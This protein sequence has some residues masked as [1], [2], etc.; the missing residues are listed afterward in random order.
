MKRIVSW[1]Y[2]HIVLLSPKIEV[3]MRKLYWGNQKLFK[4]FNPFNHKVDII[5]EDVKL[6]F[7]DVIN[8]LKDNGVGPGTLLIV[9]SSYDVIKCFGLSPKE[10][11]DRLLN[12]IGETGTLAMPA[13]RVYTEFGTGLDKMKMDPSGIIC[14]Y[15]K[16]RTPIGTGMLPFTMVR[17]KR[18]VISP[19]PINTM[20]AIGP[21]AEAMMEK[22]MNGECPSPSGPN[23]SWKFCLDHNAKVIGLGVDLEHH[24]SILHTA[25]EAFGDWPWSDEEWY[26]RRHFN[27]V[28]DDKSII[29]RDVYERRPVWGMLHIAEKNLTNYLNKCGVYHRQKIGGLI[30]V[31][32]EDAQEALMCL[33]KKNK[34]G[35]PYFK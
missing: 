1:L 33:R 26:W 2:N 30:P 18:A 29:Q 17:D 9:H 24:N 7:N 21:L 5:N 12:L 27:L 34:N 4:R 28:Q 13:I 22:N 15:D 16:K 6:D 8:F 19:H 35:Y 10:I 3:F 14:T 20:V 11:I 32:F 25:E 31:C 23:S